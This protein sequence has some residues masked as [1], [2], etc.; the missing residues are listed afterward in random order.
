MALTADVRSTLNAR[1]QLLTALVLSD[2]L[3]AVVPPDFET[4]GP[5]PA[6]RGLEIYHGGYRA[7]LSEV[8]ADHYP[9]AVR[10]VGSE[11][12][13]ALA[14]RY[15]EGHVPEG[16]HLGRY[17]DRFPQWLAE[18]HPEH[19]VLRE[20]AELEWALRTA[21]DEVD[22]KAWDLR[23][24]E[25]EG[26]QACL[27]QWPVLHPSL[28]FLSQQTNAVAIW[29]AIADDVDVPEAVLRD[30]PLSLV[31]W[32][33]GVQPCFRTLLPDEF[34]FLKALGT[35]GHSIARE[36]ERQLSCGSLGDPG[37]LA[38][39]LHEWWAGELLAG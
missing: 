10:Y 17:G 38:G 11:Y 19:P 3:P 26:S 8:L 16:R 24:I 13:N 25:T 34:E 35:P 2:M 39:W 9:K 4:P 29:K 27:E 28:R 23:R 33:Q 15:V 18:I 31:V 1:Q 36:V 5:L 37:I 6:R 30:A 20:L 7:R 14:H 22:A 21:F 32:R 12:F